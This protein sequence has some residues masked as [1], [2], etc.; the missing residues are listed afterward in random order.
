MAELERYD[1]I[2]VGTALPPF[3]AEPVSR[4]ALALYCGASGDHN[5]IH[6]DT[7]FARAAG[8]DDV[9][10]HGMLAF[11]YAARLVT[12]WIPQRAIESLSARFVAVTHVGDRL[13]CS[14]TV[15]E[16]L[17]HQRVRIALSVVDQHGV[18]KLAGEAVVALA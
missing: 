8:M 17:D 4:L 12:G 15:A 2:E 9:I 18:Q 7:D 1:Q 10:A 3:D 11:A 14:G 13:T 16:R 6:V 5:P